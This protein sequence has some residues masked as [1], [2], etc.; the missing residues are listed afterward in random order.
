MVTT[1]RKTLE[2]PRFD[3]MKPQDEQVF[4]VN[5]SSTDNFALTCF[6][7]ETL[8]KAI[9]TPRHHRTSSGRV[10]FSFCP[11]HDLR[12]FKQRNHDQITS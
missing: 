11:F 7:D 2:A 3:F 6:V 8:S 5:D 4:D 10:N 12:N 9:V 1:Q